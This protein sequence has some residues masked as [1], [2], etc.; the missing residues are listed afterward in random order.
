MK[1][2]PL[3]FRR[4]SRW[5]AVSVVGN[6]P[7]VWR[8]WAILGILAWCLQPGH[9]AAVP[10]YLR[11]V[12]AGVE[13]PAPG[14]LQFWMELGAAPPQDP[15]SD[16]SITYIFHVDTD[17][18]GQTGQKHG[19]IGSEYNVRAVVRNHVYHGGGFI[20]GIDGRPGGT[21]P[22]FIDS[23][24]V[25][26]RV[27]EAQLGSP[28]EQFLWNCAAFT[29]D[30]Q[31]QG[32]LS[33]RAY[34]LSRRPSP[35][36]GPTR[37]VIQPV[38]ACSTDPIP[39]A[40]LIRAFDI[41]NEPVALEGRTVKLFAYYGRAQAP[42][43][44]LVV[45]REQA[46]LE[47]LTAMV[48]G[49]VS[50]NIARMMVGSI[51]MAPAVLHLQPDSDLKGKAILRVTDANGDI[52]PL[53]DH[54]VTYRSDAPGIAAVAADGS[55]Q[56]T[57]GGA[58]QSTCVRSEFDGTPAANHCVVRV[59]LEPMPLLEEREAPGQQIDF[60]YP[61]VSTNPPC[62]RFEE[63]IQ[64]YA[65]VETLDVAYLRMCELT[66]TRPHGGGRLHIAAICED[67]QFRLCGAAGGDVGLGFD[68]VKSVSCVQLPNGV[69]H[70]GVACHEI[71][72]CFVGE[73]TSLFQI[74][75]RNEPGLTSGFI[76][77]EGLATLCNMY[78]R[79]MILDCPDHYGVPDSILATFT[80]PK[81]YD[82]LP[83]HRRVFVDNRLADYL[84]GRTAYP[85]DCTP[86]VL[87]GMLMV[88]AEQ[89][90]WEI[91]PRFFSVFYPPDEAID[92]SP[93]TETER[94]TFFIA[95]MS[96]AAKD[97]LRATFTVWKLPC[98]DALFAEWLPVLQWRAAQRD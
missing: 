32:S 55:I 4:G 42:A 18:N 35:G 49:V 2:I 44:E 67:E 19:T 61:P 87:D 6:P 46:G 5:S 66:G 59:L 96:A 50:A 52:V 20:D 41:F 91:F 26:L 14:V 70:W 23:G 85:D 17:C 30:G 21:M 24:R 1:T 68:P 16:H 54:Q 94:A 56:G 80:D 57:I 78:A 64:Q 53:A 40:G 10:D 92:F 71:G 28:T 37:V 82:S 79:T 73:I 75:I 83:F 43:D 72:H 81:V 89:Y 27:T 7:P 22:I 33:A 76:F 51:E 77:S 13:Q 15:N 25:Y 93:T 38:V 60:W 74:L 11:I 12:Q 98:D 86:D 8:L 48:D 9:A 95:A 47:K 39:I 36:D 88:L 84:G 29:W 97:D 31:H 58:G 62:C 3:R 63:M 69:P 90:G 45:A 34:S 65:Y